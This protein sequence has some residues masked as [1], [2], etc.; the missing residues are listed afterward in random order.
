MSGA[1][2]PDPQPWSVVARN[3][4]EHARN[5]IHTDA[6]A[7]AAGFPGAL[8]AGVTTYAY[9]THPVLA[10]WGL[11]WLA[12]GG[13]QVRFRAPVLAGDL[14]QCVPVAEPDGSVTVEARVSD[15]PLARAVVHAWPVDE[16]PVPGRPGERLP[17]YHV[18]LNDEFGPDYGVRAGDDLDLCP[19]ED[20]VHPAVWLALANNIFH[21]HLVRGAWIHTRSIVTH[22]GVARAGADIT[23]STTVVERFQRSG[24]RAIADLVIRAG[25]E[26]VALVEHEAIIDLSTSDRS[27]RP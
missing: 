6:G 7:K 17:E 10:A 14:V 18:V 3:L 27:A 24:E 20:V 8:V 15:S 23:I 13:C 21:Q 22:R 2:R 11:D 5:A 12:H 25:G 26:I 19:L 9:L 4:P 1:T 16:R